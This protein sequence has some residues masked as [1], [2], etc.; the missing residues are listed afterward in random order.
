MAATEVMDHLAMAIRKRRLLIVCGAGL[1]VLPP[2]SVPGWWNLNDLLLAEIK[3]SAATV[4]TAPAA[5]EALESLSM[6]RLSI[7]SFSEAIVDS[8]AGDSYFSVLTARRSRPPRGPPRHRH[9]EFPH[10]D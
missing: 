9:C 2:S 5:H 3:D 1:S 10:T 7:V 8:F 4:L 6:D